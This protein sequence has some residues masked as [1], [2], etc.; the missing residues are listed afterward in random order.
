MKKYIIIQVFFLIFFS[1]FLQ[2]QGKKNILLITIDTLRY[3]RLSIYNDK[4]VKT[5]NIDNLAKKGAVFERAFAHTPITLPSHANILTGTTPLYHGISDNNRFRLDDKF[6]TLAEHLKKN[7]YKTAA[8]TASFVLN[9]YFKLNQGFDL[10]SGP[11]KSN[12]LKAE[13]IIKPSVKWIRDN[14]GPWFLWI[15]VWDP[16]TPYSP[17]EP[18]KTRFSS[19]LYSG[20]VAYTDSQLGTLFDFMEDSGLMK[21]TSIVITGDHGEALGD[22]YE[23]EHGYFAYNST[24]HIPLIIYDP[25]IKSS[26]ICNNVS[27]IDIFPTLCNLAKVSTP[28]HIQGKSLLPLMKGETWEEETIYFESKLA[29]YSRGW[30]P[31]DGFIKEDQKFI[32]QPIKELYDLKKDFSEKRNI[33]S[34]VTDC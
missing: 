19:D 22:H 5:P 9:E 23:L 25:S 13:E 24:I 15:H 31:L 10:Y 27:H 7:G 16:H 12:E 28:S 21:N 14:K 4:F 18:F 26:T 20:E 8:F 17:P 1:L 2:G 11:E 32:N 6:L 29:Y 33:I 34:G 3:D 30:A